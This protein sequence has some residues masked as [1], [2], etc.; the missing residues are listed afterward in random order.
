MRI[1]NK[2][3]EAGKIDPVQQAYKE[4]DIDWNAVGPMVAKE[5]A[6]K[7]IPYMAKDTLSFID[8]WL[9]DKGVPEMQR[10]VILG[11]IIIESGGSPSRPSTTGP[12]PTYF[13][14]LQ[15]SRDRLKKRT[16]GYAGLLAQLEKIYKE[17][18]SPT[19]WT[20]GFENAGFTY[21][22]EPYNNFQ[23]PDT[24]SR[25]IPAK[26]HLRQT[27][28]N[29]ATWGF[30]GGYIRPKSTVYETILRATAAKAVQQN[31]GK[32]TNVSSK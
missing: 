6:D 22:R 23:R 32:K 26:F 25:D 1:I 28:Q 3:Q 27:P 15:W 8:K 9:A 13:G 5:K 14:L 21:F 10:N 18:N 7:S 29:K 12:F 4:S 17:I 20:K 24:T 31:R 16:G 11:N 19:T 30:V 2:Y